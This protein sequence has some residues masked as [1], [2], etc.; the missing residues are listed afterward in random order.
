[1]ALGRFCRQLGEL[2]HLGSWNCQF[3][4]AHSLSR[5]DQR[6]AFVSYSSIFLIGLRGR[7]P[8]DFRNW[9]RRHVKDEIEG[10]EVKVR[11]SAGL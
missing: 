11:F 1:M 10:W 6:E 7:K 5:T 4:P 2:P 8:G 9:S 3:L